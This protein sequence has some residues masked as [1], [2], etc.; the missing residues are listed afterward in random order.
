MC[1]VFVLSKSRL[2]TEELISDPQL[3]GFNILTN[4]FWLALL[5]NFRI[6]LLTYCTTFCVYSCLPPWLILFYFPLQIPLP[7][8]PSPPYIQY[9]L[10]NWADI[11]LWSHL[12]F[13]SLTSH[14]FKAIYLNS[15]F[16][17]A[18][19]LTLHVLITFCFTTPSLSKK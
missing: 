7:H 1:N 5:T 9:T 3:W 19:R 16:L 13:S 18:Y 15:Q 4:N 12:S 11:V 10:K 17:W 6:K 2:Y 14:V 8:L